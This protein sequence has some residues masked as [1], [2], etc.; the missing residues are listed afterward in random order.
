MS[1]EVYDLDAY[2]ELRKQQKQQFI[3]L[4]EEVVLDL[5]AITITFT[6]DRLIFSSTPVQSDDAPAT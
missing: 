2:R 5:P 6:D 3:Q 1:A 4:V